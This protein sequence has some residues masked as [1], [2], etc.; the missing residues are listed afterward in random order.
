MFFSELCP[1]LENRLAL[2]NDLSPQVAFQSLSMATL[3]SISHVFGSVTLHDYLCKL[4]P[5]GKRRG[6]Q[7]GRRPKPQPLGY[8]DCPACEPRS[9]IWV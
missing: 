5:H 2:L 9:I 3:G 8:T 7:S 4:F 6:V 1:L